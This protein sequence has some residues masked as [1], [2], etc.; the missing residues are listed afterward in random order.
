MLY[1]IITNGSN[2]VVDVINADNPPQ[3]PPTISGLTFYAVECSDNVHVNMVYNPDTGE[4]TE[5]VKPEPEPTPSIY[6]EP[7]LLQ[8]YTTGVESIG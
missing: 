4:F 6:S 8:E 5:P 1:A 3:Y 2:A 7:E